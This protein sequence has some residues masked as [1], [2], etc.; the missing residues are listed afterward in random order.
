MDRIWS[1][2]LACARSGRPLAHDTFRRLR[3]LARPLADLA[4]VSPRTGRSIY[5]GLGG[6]M[7]FVTPSRARSFT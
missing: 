3:D 7:P 6:I 4:K 1:L 5:E 2:L